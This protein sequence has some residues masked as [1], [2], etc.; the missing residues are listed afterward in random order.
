[1]LPVPACD[2]TGIW[3]LYGE[4]AEYGTSSIF[5]VISRVARPLLYM[6][7]IMRRVD[8]SLLHTP[9]TESRLSHTC[10]AFP[11]QWLCIVC[12]QF[13]GGGSWRVLLPYSTA[14]WTDNSSCPT[15]DIHAWIESFWDVSSNPNSIVM[16]L[17]QYNGCT[18]ARCCRG[19]ALLS[20]GPTYV[21]TMLVLTTSS[22]SSPSSSTS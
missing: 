5:D 14:P 3:T 11:L 12:I 2:P 1:M 10:L 8:V 7:Q 13:G 20:D 21:C 16:R 6:P 17:L 4:R 22:S 19:S 18:L 15:F 9:G